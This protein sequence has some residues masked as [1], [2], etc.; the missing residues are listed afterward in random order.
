MLQSNKF[1]LKD[2]YGV[3][4]LRRIL[5]LLRSEDGCPWD[6]VQT[7]QTIRANLLEEAY[8]A[9]DAID[10]ADDTALCEEL[11]DV[12]LQVVFHARMAEETGSFDLD[13]VADGI[14]KKLILRHPHV[15]GDVQADTPEQVLNNWEQIKQ[16]EKHQETAAATLE[17]V[18][19]AFPALMRAQKVQKRAGKA[20]FDWPDIQGALDKLPEEMAELKEALAAGDREAISDE[21]G[22]LFFAAVN[23]ARFAGVDAEETLQRS[24][25]K[26]IRRFANLEALAAQRGLDMKRTPIRELDKLWE[27]VKAR[28]SDR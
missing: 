25:D 13:Q 2:A 22:D 9:A 7:H 28:P 14:C 3:E 1:Q 17:S 4:D 18:P 26:F 24:T 16:V 20:G 10:Q 12:L 27:E 5:E 19:K 8:E 23:A 6:R 21:M 15:F 11:G